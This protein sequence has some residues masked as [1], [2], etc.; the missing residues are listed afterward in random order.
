MSTR[1]QVG[2]ILDPT[3]KTSAS[4]LSRGLKSARTRRSPGPPQVRASAHGEACGSAHLGPPRRRGVVAV[5]VGVVM[6][7]LIG[8]AALTVDVG[9]LYNTR[10][11]L[12]RCSDAASLA[13][14]SAFATDAMMQ[15]RLGTGSKS[16]VDTMAKTR[17]HEFAAKNGTF[18]QTTTKIAS[19]DISVGWIKANS[20][21]E[22]IH[23]NRQAGDMPA[24]YVMSRRQ[25]GE[26]TNGP[27]PLFFTGIFGKLFGES[28][29]SAV[30]IFDD[31]V[32]GYTPGLPGTANLLPFTVHED[33]YNADLVAGGDQWGWDQDAGAVYTG[34]DGIR[35]VR[36]YPY[37]LSGTPETAPNGA[38]NFGTL[39]VGNDSQS[40]DVERQ[41]VTNGITGAELEAEIGTPEATFY[42]DAGNPI[43]YDVTGSPGLTAAL[44]KTIDLKEGQI[45]G[46][47]LHNYYV[48]T[49]SNL[50][51]TIT[52]IRFGRVMHVDLTGNQ[53]KP[54]YGFFIQPVSYSGGGVIID[55]QAPSTNGQ[56]GRLVLAR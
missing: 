19:Q 22:A 53:N 5:Q 2:R 54:G 26:D 40:A 35:E 34:N 39:N 12:Q 21:S 49:G 23:S 50:V 3:R 24:V 29:A 17:V 51:Y 15:W 43:T 25:E 20:P 41:Q 30:A 37:P 7:V 9:T 38:G 13:G 14:A 42:D 47:F 1:H 11:D 36:I 32:S 27:I 44:E 6:I 55:P 31:R 4:H 48:D 18:G 56:V 52:A 16:L 8:F 28:T 10:G 45:V 33:A 46:F